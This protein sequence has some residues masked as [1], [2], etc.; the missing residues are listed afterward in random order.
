MR[1]IC[2]IYVPLNETSKNN[3]PFGRGGL[4]KHFQ[5]SACDWY[6]KLNL[7]SIFFTFLFALRIFIWFTHIPAYNQFGESLNDHKLSLT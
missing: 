7:Y 4:S 2:C 3:H 1:D 5:M 6:E